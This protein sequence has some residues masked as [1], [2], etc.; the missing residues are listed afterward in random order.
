MVRAHTMTSPGIGGLLARTARGAGWVMA[1]RLGMRALGLVSTLILVRLLA[2]ADFGLMALATG[3][4]QTIDGMLLLGIEEAVIRDDAPDR[5]TYDTAFTL[6]V[7]RG[8]A[9]SLLVAACAIPA[10]DF[11]GDSRLTPVLLFVACLPLLDGLANIGAVDFRRDMAFQKEFALMV[12]PKLGGILAAII[13][14]I[15]LH[16]YVAMLFGI[17]VNRVLRTVMTYV[18]HPYRPR[19]SLR[20]WRGLA[21]Y[22]VWSWL[23]SLAVLI[24]DR[25]DTLLLGRMLGAAPLGIWSVGVEVAALPTTEL[26][27]PLGRAAFSGFAEARRSGMPAATLFVRVIAGAAV[28]AIPAG[29]GLSLV[30]GPLVRVALGAGWQDVVP[31]LRI[32]A[33]AGTVTALGHLSL[34]L[35][36]VHALLRRLAIV[37]LL[38]AAI[39]IALILWLIPGFGL[40]AAAW[41]IAAAT[42]V[43]QGLTVTLAMTRFRVAPSAMLAVIWR[44]I[45]A[46]GAMALVL[47]WLNL[48]W[49]DDQAEWTA[50]ALITGI[51]AGGITYMAVLLGCWL[52]AD[53]PDGIEASAVTAL[54]DRFNGN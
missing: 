28:L 10:G 49:T 29:I 1:W 25:C 6:N 17:G 11:F 19:L 33:I 3:F 26:V 38:G 36:S 41:A 51:G 50:G 54:R 34:H 24:R 21:G 8:A 53:R 15:L 30:A 23:L 32:L 20:A 52:A 44:P 45:A 22:S 47:C 4:M 35:L 43:E 12:L 7:L 5:A 13:A 16:S 2:P 37:T 39:R 31:V 14:A 46:A 48:G 40:P 42:L 18:M 27:E 9:V